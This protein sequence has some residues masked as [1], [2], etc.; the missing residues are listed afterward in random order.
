MIRSA[1]RRLGASRAVP[2]RRP[3][4]PSI[5]CLEAR[6]V[7]S[8]PYGGGP[9]PGYPGYG[10]SPVMIRAPYAPYGNS[11]VIANLP[12]NV[13][14]GQNLVFAVGNNALG[15]SVTAWVHSPVPYDEEVPG[16]GL[17][18][19]R[20]T[21]QGAASSPVFLEGFDLDASDGWVSYPTTVVD[22]AVAPDGGFGVAYVREEFHFPQPWAAADV[23]TTTV[24]VRTFDAA[25]NVVGGPQPIDTVSDTDPFDDVDHYVH[26]PRLGADASGGFTVAWQRTAEDDYT[27]LDE[28]AA[29][30]TDLQVARVGG[31]AATVA[32]F[33]ASYDPET[34]IS[35]G[36]VVDQH[37]LATNAAGQSVVAWSRLKVD[38]LDYRYPRADAVYAQRVT[39]AGA[40]TG[41]RETVSLNTDS[42]EEAPAAEVGIDAAG[43]FAVSWMYTPAP[44][45]WAGAPVTATTGIYA[46]RFDAAGPTGAE[47]LVVP[48]QQMIGSPPT[49]QTVG[50]ASNTTGMAATGDF[51]VGWYEVLASGTRRLRAQAFTAAGEK[52]GDRFSLLETPDVL[53]DGHVGPKIV[54]VALDDDGDM[55]GVWG[56]TAAGSPA[57]VRARRFVRADFDVQH[58]EVQRSLVRY[59]DITFTSTAVDL[60]GLLAAGRLQ[61]T[62]YALT[63]SG[64][65]TAVSLAGTTSVAGTT[66][67]FDFGPAGLA[68]GYYVLEADLDG[69]G[70][71]E[72]AWRFYRKA[73][74][75][76]GTGLNNY[77]G[78]LPGLV[79]ND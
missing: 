33:A 58:G 27:T 36:D 51:V 63:G 20:M 29:K 9:P 56:Q 50:M 31:A 25:G 59:L 11:A 65:G 71:F 14:H 22:V 61:L 13:N 43:G 7:P 5:E 70:L 3:R 74:D 49:L 53:P 79:L 2:A 64:P 26:R 72:A 42:G 46:R 4:R 52:H 68:D 30:Y 8:G 67:S 77:P 78:L 57:A 73:G 54:Q 34:G 48:T 76:T 18:F 24:F 21:R 75:M 62:R 19:N 6:D 40:L 23:H 47:Q 41:V 32:T 28:P 1:L 66:L 12:S 35:A 69:D 45:G 16:N 38:V 17:Y 15:D 37:D 44:Y 10:N 55:V 39:A 60:S